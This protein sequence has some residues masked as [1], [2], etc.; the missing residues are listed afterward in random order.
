MMPHLTT[1][2]LAC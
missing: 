2:L 1:W